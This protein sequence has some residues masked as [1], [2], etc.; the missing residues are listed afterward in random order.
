MSAQPKNYSHLLFFML[1]YV[2]I[3]LRSENSVLRIIDTKSYPCGRYFSA[4]TIN[5]RKL[6]YKHSKAISNSLVVYI[7][8]FVKPELKFRPH[9]EPFSMS[10]NLGRILSMN[11][12]SDI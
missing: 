4:D 9:V 6:K 12:T 7:N 8:L 2:L 3:A 1:F 11:V 5:I 10:G